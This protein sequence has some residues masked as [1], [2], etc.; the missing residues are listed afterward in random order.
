VRCFSAFTEGLDAL[1]EWLKVCGVTT[2]AIESTGV[3][4]IALCQ[5][6]S[7][8]L[9]ASRCFWSMPGT[10]ATFP[11]AR[12]TLRTASGS[13]GGWFTSFESSIPGTQCAAAGDFTACTLVGIPGLGG[14]HFRA[15]RWLRE[16]ILPLT[17]SLF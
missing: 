5:K 10:Y 3:Y 15:E 7:W 8:K 11:D 16:A 6:L 17:V 12:L 9:P 1:V 4:W 14:T 13:N 2:V